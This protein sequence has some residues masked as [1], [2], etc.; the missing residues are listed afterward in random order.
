MRALLNWLLRVFHKHRPLPTG[1]VVTAG[2]EDLKKNI[3]HKRWVSLTRTEM[4]DCS[5]GN[6]FIFLDGKL[7]ELIG[8]DDDGFRSDEICPA[9][10][11]AGTI[12]RQ[13]ERQESSGRVDAV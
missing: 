8:V 5:C 10:G 3:P 7:Y 13:P 2:F 11:I 12:P 1:C 9:A 4:W 6:Q